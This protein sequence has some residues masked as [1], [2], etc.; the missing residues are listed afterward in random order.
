MAE[1][2]SAVLRRLLDGSGAEGCAVFRTGGLVV[3]AVGQAP[4]YAPE[5]N[6]ARV[7]AVPITSEFTLV[8]AL[9]TKSQL[10]VARLRIRQSIDAVRA[11]LSP[12]D[13]GPDLPS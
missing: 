3:A 2:L 8:V 10:G 9:A 7:Q 6:D 13:P 4:S 1:Q 11:A 12:L 5:S